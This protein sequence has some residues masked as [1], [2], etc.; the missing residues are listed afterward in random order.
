MTEREKILKAALTAATRELLLERDCLFDC[1]TDSEGRF[2]DPDDEEAVR[3]L[4]A[5]IDQCR[6]ALGIDDLQPLRQEHEH[7]H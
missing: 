4:D 7:V 2:T 6:Q 1:S 3:E 5:L